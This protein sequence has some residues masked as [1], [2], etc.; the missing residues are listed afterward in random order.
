MKQHVNLIEKNGFV[1]STLPAL[2]GPENSLVK[3]LLRQNPELVPRSCKT[4]DLESL[5]F[6]AFLPTHKIQAVGKKS[7]SFYLLHQ[8]MKV[9]SRHLCN[10]RARETLCKSRR[11]SSVTAQNF[12]SE[13]GG[14]AKPQKLHLWESLGNISPSDPLKSCCHRP[15]ARSPQQKEG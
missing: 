7:F 10:T 14:D 5:D 8:E 4:S 3:Y 1:T 2:P 11:I 13:R 6:F 12:P 15:Q 9:L